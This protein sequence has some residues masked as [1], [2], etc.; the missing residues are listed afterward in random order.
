MP[1][2]LTRGDFLKIGHFAP[3][4]EFLHIKGRNFPD[5]FFI[6][7]RLAITFMN[8]EKFHGNRSARF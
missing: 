3:F 2:R 7:S 5:V 6:R 8:Q 4:S 1:A